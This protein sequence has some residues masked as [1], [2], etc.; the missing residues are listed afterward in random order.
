MNTFY[1]KLLALILILDA[2]WIGLF[3]G[4]PFVTMVENIQGSPVKTNMLGVGIAYVSLFLLAAIFLPKTSSDLEAFL[5]GALTY[6]V[7]D[8]TNLALF[9][10]YSTQLAALDILWGGTLFYLL[11]KILF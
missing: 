3:L 8:G 1:I 11:K 2:L 10:G 5:L 9:T 6:A 4:K 7:Y